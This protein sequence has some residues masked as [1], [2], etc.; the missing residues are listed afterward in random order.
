METYSDVSLRAMQRYERLTEAGEWR[1]H[2][3]PMDSEELIEELNTGG[4]YIVGGTAIRGCAHSKLLISEARMEEKKIAITFSGHTCE[5]CA[6][7]SSVNTIKASSEDIVLNS[8]WRVAIRDACPYP[9]QRSMVDG[10]AVFL[11]LGNPEIERNI[12]D[13][14]RQ[15]LEIRRKEWQLEEE[16]EKAERVAVG[17]EFLTKLQSSFGGKEIDSFRLESGENRGTVFQIV[18]SDESVLSVELTRS[19]PE[20]MFDGHISKLEVEGVEIENFLP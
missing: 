4:W 15:E 10:K 6:L 18:L 14:E 13:V 5:E 8:Y 12:K 3:L 16:R 17:K 7:S 19:Y 1:H 2:G 11:R 9:E 20:E